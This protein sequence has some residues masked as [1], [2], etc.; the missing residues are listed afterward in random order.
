MNWSHHWNIKKAINTKIAF[1]VKLA[2]NLEQRLLCIF[3][4]CNLIYWF[5]LIHV[6]FRLGHAEMKKWK[7]PSSA[8]LSPTW[9]WH[10][11]PWLINTWAS[12]SEETQGTVELFRHLVFGKL[13]RLNISL[14]NYIE[15]QINW[16][17]RKGYNIY[18][19]TVL[20][21]FLIPMRWMFWCIILSYKFGV[22][23]EFKLHY[24]VY[25]QGLTWRG[26]N[27]HSAP[28]T[29]KRS[30][31]F[32]GRVQLGCIQIKFCLCIF[33]IKP[34]RK[35]SVKRWVNRRK[36]ILNDACKTWISSLRHQQIYHI[37]VRNRARPSSP[38]SKLSM[39]VQLV[40]LFFVS[41][42]VFVFLSFSFLFYLLNIY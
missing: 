18:V 2:S 16:R 29:W 35:K 7:G 42:S 26:E 10:W 25:Q 27:I 38:N 32:R 24:L 5:L 28:V 4:I 31:T 30:G 9:A 14:Q 34:L 11:V 23:V 1:W 8:C 22:K 17:H 19:S 36:E 6:P 20:C 39:L 41:Q 40:H 37:P 15:F 33:I 21:L 12:S 3:C 13:K